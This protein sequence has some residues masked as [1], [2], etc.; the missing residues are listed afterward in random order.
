M[1]GFDKENV[2][3]DNIFTSEICTHRVVFMEMINEITISSQEPKKG[4][5]QFLHDAER[6]AV[7]FGNFMWK[8]FT[9]IGPRSEETC[10]FERYPDMEEGR[11]A[12]HFHPS[13][14][15]SALFCADKV[16]FVARFWC[17]VQFLML[18]IAFWTV[19]VVLYLLFSSH[20]RLL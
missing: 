8:Y 12:S 18:V 16:C 17:F 19:G 9:H 20:L 5:A 14:L 13:S 10:I 7:C 6:N 2:N 4:G 15:R 11:E 3:M 1:N